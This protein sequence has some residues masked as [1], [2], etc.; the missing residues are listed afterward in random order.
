[1]NFMRMEA[2]ASFKRVVSHH[3]VDLAH[4]VKITK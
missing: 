2:L 1:M 3:E 4:F